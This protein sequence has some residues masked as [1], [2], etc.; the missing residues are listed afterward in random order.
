MRKIMSDNDVTGHFRRLSEICQSADWV[1]FWESLGCEICT[2]ADVGLSPDAKDAEVWRVCQA[3]DVV[4]IT[5]NR[6]AEGPDSLEI[7]IRAQNVPQ[8]LPVLTLADPDR[9][10]QDRRYAE[11]VVERLM[12]ILME[13]ESLR[14]AGRLYLP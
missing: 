7:T 8:S 12:E 5:G 4:L 2:F 13:I 14:G 1:D 6:N 11:A 10:L 9:V 3:R